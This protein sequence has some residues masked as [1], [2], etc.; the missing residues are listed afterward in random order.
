MEIE[1][2]AGPLVRWYR[3]EFP[4]GGRVGDPPE[5]ADIQAL[6][7][8]WRAAFAPAVGPVAWAEDVAAPFAHARIAGDAWLALRWVAAA[9]SEEVDQDDWDGP[10]PEDAD[11]HPLMAELHKKRPRDLRFY[12]LLQPTAWIPTSFD[13]TLAIGL[14]DRPTEGRIASVDRFYAQLRELNMQVLRMTS[15]QLEIHRAAAQGTDALDLARHAVAKA[16]PVAEHAAT[17]RTVL[18]AA[19]I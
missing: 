10:L 15:D 13:G 7:E 2:Y 16:L 19:E 8:K 14:P 5:I 9:V 1:L 6:A 11:E 12:A 3:Q 17:A 4:G 18:L